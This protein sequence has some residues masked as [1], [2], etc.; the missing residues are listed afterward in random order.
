M[1]TSTVPFAQ[2]GSGGT[3]RVTQ[4]AHGFTQ[5]QAIQLDGATWALAQADDSGTLAV[6]LAD[7]IDAN[8]FRVVHSGTVNGL[9]GLTA[10]DYYYV[11]STTAGALTSTEPVT[12]FSNPILLATS[13]TAGVVL[14]Y[15]PS[16]V[17]VAAMSY[18]TGRVI[19]NNYATNIANGDHIKFDAVM[20]QAGSDIGLDTTTPYTNATG[21]ASLGRITL[22]GG[23]VYELTQQVFAAGSGGYMFLAWYNS[24]TNTL[25]DQGFFLTT[26]NAASTNTTT[27]SKSTIFAPAIQTR[28]ELRIYSIS[29][30]TTIYGP[31]AGMGGGGSAFSVKTIGSVVAPVTQRHE[32]KLHTQGGWGSTAT[33]I[34]YFTAVA[35]NLGTAITL[36]QSTVN[37]D[38]FT[39]NDSGMYQVNGYF[40]PTSSATEGITINAPTLTSNIELQPPA[41]TL[42]ICSAAGAGY[43]DECSWTGWLQAG[44]VVRWH[45][46]ATTTTSSAHNK[47]E[48]VKIG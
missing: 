7:V 13:A 10:G 37:G 4:A 6:G 22:A 43:Y 26:D 9:A 14:P 1:S 27:S 39:I 44:T 34:K 46:Q 48:I 23:K 16:G 11:S 33:K 32:V 29:G 24:D 21:V 3:L 41:N 28:V 35:S 12:G 15:R 31:T 25:I 17:G 45:G 8:T 5:G 47:F 36:T 20:D 19:T 30:I 38:S 42:T 2:S 18:L 40:W